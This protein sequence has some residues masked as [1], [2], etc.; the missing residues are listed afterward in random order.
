MSESTIVLSH[1]ERVRDAVN[2]V[3][4][5]KRSYDEAHDATSRALAEYIRCQELETNLSNTLDK[6]RYVLQQVSESET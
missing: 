3:R 4:H 1:E 5:L 6:A 2:E